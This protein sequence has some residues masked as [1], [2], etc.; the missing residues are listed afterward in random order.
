MI[1]WKVTFEDVQIV[2]LCVMEVKVKVYPFFGNL[3][4]IHHFVGNIQGVNYNSF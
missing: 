1:N 2:A 4:P 3:K